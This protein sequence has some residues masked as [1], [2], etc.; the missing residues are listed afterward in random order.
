M[1]KELRG[2]LTPTEFNLI[3]KQVQEEIYRG[4][5][6]DAN[7]DAFK[8]RRGMSSR[9]PGNLLFN[10]TEKIEEFITEA[11]L[12]ISAGVYPLPANLYY[13]VDRGVSIGGVLIDYCP[14]SESALIGQ[15]IGGPSTSFPVYKKI[16]SDIKVLP[17]T[18]VADVDITYLRKPLDPKWTYTVVSNNELFNAAANDYQDFE[19]HT[20]EFSNIAVRMLSYFGVNIRETEVTQYAEALKQKSEIRE[21]S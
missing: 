10:Q 7:R 4:Y 13:L 21:E 9:G 1:N 18:I 16:G 20:S 2:N 14:P 5:F 8:E 19:L 3:A 12:T 11:A 6:E 17:A 15:S